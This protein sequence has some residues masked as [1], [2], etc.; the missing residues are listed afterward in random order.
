MRDG[1]TATS[2]FITFGIFPIDPDPSILH[3]NDMDVGLGPRGRATRGRGQ[4]DW[5]AIPDTSNPGAHSPLECAPFLLPVFLPA[6]LERARGPPIS[7]KSRNAGRF[8][9]AVLAVV[10]GD[11]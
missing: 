10:S 8:R 4:A 5:A 11:C 2:F 7:S 1:A 9:A 3:L 6:A